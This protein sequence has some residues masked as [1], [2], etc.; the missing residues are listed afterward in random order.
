VLTRIRG[1]SRNFLSLP[2]VTLLFLVVTV[3]LATLVTLR[4]SPPAQEAEVEAE[5]T[6]DTTA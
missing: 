4:L 3:G 5:A 6:A 1:I 2:R